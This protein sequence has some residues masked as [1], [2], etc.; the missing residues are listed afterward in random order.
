MEDFAYI[1]TPS[2]R[3]VCVIST[4]SRPFNEGLTWLLVFQKS[5]SFSFDVALFK[6]CCGQ[7]CQL[8]N[9]QTKNTKLGKFWR[10]LQWKA[11]AYFIAIWSI[12]V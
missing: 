12:L 11:L 6:I 2:I 10:V 3:L 8:A 1:H 5:T 9:F 7:G 4:S